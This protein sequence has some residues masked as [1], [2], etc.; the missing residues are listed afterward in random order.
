V[1]APHHEPVI[2]IDADINQPCSGPS[3]VSVSAAS[4]RHCL[5][6]GEAG[7]PRAEVGARLGCWE[8]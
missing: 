7:D 3:F 2:A 1:H 6:A 5:D 4:L 8:T